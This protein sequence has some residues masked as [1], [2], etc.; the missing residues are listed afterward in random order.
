MSFDWCDYLRLAQSEASDTAGPACS[1]REAKLR[2]AVSRAYYAAFCSAR[3]HA[4][5]FDGLSFPKS[6]Q[7]HTLVRE[8]FASRTGKHYQRVAIHLDLLRNDRNRADYDNAVSGLEKVTAKC[9][10]RAA[11][12]IS[13]LAAI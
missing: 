1:W 10:K 4:I 3:N 12:V 6:A 13:Q 5:S 8:H 11:T 2:S 7:A 9:L